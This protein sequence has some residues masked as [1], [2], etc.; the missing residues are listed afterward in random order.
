MSDELKMLL[1]ANSLEEWKKKLDQL[2]MVLVL[3]SLNLNFD[4]VR[5]Y[6][7]IGEEVPSMES[8]RTRLLCVPTKKSGDTLQGDE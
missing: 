5:D 3:C 8:L 2:Y 7:L 6:I 4:N 1:E